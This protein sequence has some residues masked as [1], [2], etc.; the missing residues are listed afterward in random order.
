MTGQHPHRNR[1]KALHR[2][3]NFPKDERGITTEDTEFTER[4]PEVFFPRQGMMR[5]CEQAAS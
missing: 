5:D 3:A 4:E 2:I 1:R